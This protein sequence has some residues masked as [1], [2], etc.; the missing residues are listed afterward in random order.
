MTLYDYILSV[1]NKYEDLHS[2]S[3]YECPQ[4]CKYCRHSV[5]GKPAD[6]CTN[7]FC[8]REVDQTMRSGKPK[9]EE[10]LSLF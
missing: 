6:K 7:A 3:F 2:M 5:K 10:Q 1:K 4:L 8:W 9:E